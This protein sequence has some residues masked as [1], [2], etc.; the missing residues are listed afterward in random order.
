MNALRPLLLGMCLGLTT[1]AWAGTA[2]QTD[3]TTWADAMATAR[4]AYLKSP[5]AQKAAASE[6]LF[7]PFDSGPIDGRGPAKQVV[8]NIAGLKE[9]RLVATCVKSPA[10]CNI[11]GE[12]RLI[13]K[14]GSITRLTDLK[15]VSV[16]V[17]WGQLW[18]DQNWQKHPL[19]VGE[20]TFQYGLW[21]HANSELCYALDGRYERFEA[22]VGED[23][24]RVGGVVRFQV[25]S[26]ATMPS[27]WN[28]VA[29]KFPM[30]T[31]WLRSDASIDG[32]TSWFGSRQ[33]S[34]LEQ[35]LLD[36]V[37]KQISPSS[38]AIRAEMD[39]L[40][41]AGAAPGD[42]RWLQ[43]YA[44]ACR[45]RQ[46]EA[47]LD[48]NSALRPELDAL[49]AAKAPEDDPRWTSL[50]GRT[51]RAL[52]LDDQFATL[53]A[54]INRRGVLSKA[55]NERQWNGERYVPTERSAAEEIAKQVYHPASLVLPEDR[56]PADIVVRRTA[57]LLG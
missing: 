23:C 6:S 29:S 8:V 32:I 28:D 47:L 34:Q 12:P 51:L 1:T 54:D 27:A 16:Q 17:G 9:L 5:E 56:D 30:Q 39:A 55:T 46:C 48:A 26:T 10:N 7:K 38:A 42:P 3:R 19:R 21:V 36:L 33:T 41:K 37:L 43:L 11:W 52:E 31:G 20:R 40:A 57:A 18:V 25:L 44:L 53:Q 49:V 4:A 14:D 22:M 15:P 24:D 35:E 2:D 13:A 45:Y 50:R